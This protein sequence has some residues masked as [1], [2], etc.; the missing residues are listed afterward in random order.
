MRLLSAILILSMAFAGCKEPNYN[1]VATGE[2]NVTRSDSIAND[3]TGEAETETN[4]EELIGEQVGITAETD[5]VDEFDSTENDLKIDEFS[6]EST[7]TSAIGDDFNR[8]G[9]DLSS[10]DE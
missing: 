3:D 9:V 5:W 10:G 8:I 1:N 7:D 2:K 6:D 4:S